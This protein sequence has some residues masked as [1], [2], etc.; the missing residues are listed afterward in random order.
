M[1][2]ER[3]GRK[4]GRAMRERSWATGRTGRIHSGGNA[5]SGW[6]GARR[7]AGGR[8][9]GP[10]GPS[11][12]RRRS[13]RTGPMPVPCRGTPRSWPAGVRHPRTGLHARPR[14]SLQDRPTHRTLP[15]RHGQTKQGHGQNPSDK[16]TA[17]TPIVKDPA[18]L[19]RTTRTPTRTTKPE[20]PVYRLAQLPPRTSTLHKRP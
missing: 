11:L 1:A 3:A 19:L 17:T 4:P 12:R 6:R 7:K 10:R 16:N 18:P 14:P 20:G 9:S 5:Q 2:G 8:R 13:G 15:D